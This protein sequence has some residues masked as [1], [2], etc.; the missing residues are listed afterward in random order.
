MWHPK[1]ASAL[2]LAK[3]EYKEITYNLVQELA[4]GKELDKIITALKGECEDEQTEASGGIWHMLIDKSQAKAYDKIEM[5]S[6]IVS[7]HMFRDYV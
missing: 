5:E 3:G 4:L 2:G 1:C 7:S 6:C